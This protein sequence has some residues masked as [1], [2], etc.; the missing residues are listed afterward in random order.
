MNAGSTNTPVHQPFK[1]D[2]LG[3]C[4]RQSCHFGFVFV[5][6]GFALFGFGCAKTQ[7]EQY[8]VNIVLIVVDTLRVDHLGCYGYRRPLSPNIDR[9]AADGVRFENA[10][11]Q[12]PWTTPSVGSLLSSNYPTTLGITTAPNKLPDRFLVLPEVLRDHGYGTGAVVSHYFLGSKWNF[13]Q[14]FDIF[15]ERGIGISFRSAP[16]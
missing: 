11:S 13:Q 7:C 1:L 15:D 3:R 10:Y 4:Q 12:A 9:M 8:A 5:I 2:R 6:A 14:G 16:A